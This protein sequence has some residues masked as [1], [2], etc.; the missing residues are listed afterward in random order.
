MDPLERQ[1]ADAVNVA[2]SPEFVGRRRV[3][4]LVLF[5]GGA[6]L[7]AELVLGQVFPTSFLPRTHYPYLLFPLVIGAAL[8]VGPRGASLT[9]LMV[10]LIAVVCIT[11]VAALGTAAKSK[12]TETTNALK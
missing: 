9:T 3:T 5:A 2:P 12:F 4:E 10:A 8:R 11:A 6:I 7:V 1:I